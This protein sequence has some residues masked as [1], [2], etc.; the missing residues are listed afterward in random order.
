ML[1]AIG[2][3][4]FKV[5]A[6]SARI[7]V[8]P[9]TM[10]V[11]RNSSGKSSLLHALLLLK[12][13]LVERTM[14]G[15]VPQLLLN[16][17][18]YEGGTYKD[19]VYEHDTSRSLRFTFDLKLGLGKEDR[20]RFLLPI[21]MPVTYRNY[22][23]T[24][25]RHPH[26]P[27]PAPG[28]PASITLT[29]TAAEPF[30]PALSAL[31]ADIDGIGRATMSMVQNETGNT[32]LEVTNSTI[33]WSGH[34]IRCFPIG[35]LPYIDIFSETIDG[36]VRERSRPQHS[37]IS[38][39]MQSISEIS[40]FL[41]NIQFLGPFRQAPQRRYLFS[42]FSA[43]EAGKEG[44]R[45][46]D[47]LIMEHILS[48]Y[49]TGP[50]AQGVS[51]WMKRLGL[52]TDL[53]VRPLARHANLFEVRLK[54]AGYKVPANFA[55]VGFGISQ[56]LPVIVQGL[57][58]PIDG[59]YIVQQ[60]ELHLHP[61]AQAALADF[62]IYLASFGVSSIV[63]T[64][65]EY[66]LLRLRRRLAEAAPVPD[67]GLEKASGAS[68]TKIDRSKVSVLCPVDSDDEG[69]IIRPIEIDESFQFSDLPEGFMNQAVEE[70]MALLKALEA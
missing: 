59:T 6:N 25:F 51:F 58:T 57:L 26:E 40:Q 32:I 46:I 23:P 52:A 11:G 34:E 62:F 54:N 31:E 66:L 22:F 42:G 65:S 68:K 50:L 4:N 39:L 69:R 37:F 41:G 36:A 1:T 28:T 21:K 67:L 17:S 44:E 55:D 38:A 7:P 35:C 63:E 24:F 30:G 14:P 53:G 47:L 16:G 2:L 27:G 9:L 56:V 15:P 60:P 64:H 10:L 3:E 45:A 29:Y 19:I 12:Q 18:L 13:S 5:F 8:R 20:P 43:S 61:D 70:R 49:R 48:D 33:S